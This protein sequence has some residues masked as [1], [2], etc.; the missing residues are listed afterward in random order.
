MNKTLWM[1]WFQGEEDASLHGLNKKCIERWR[2]LNPDWDVR[3]IDNKDIEEII[4][5]YFEIIGKNEVKLATR[6]EVVRIL[7]LRKFGG[8]WSDA[9]VYP[10]VPL[11]EFIPKVLNDTGFF[12]YRFTPRSLCTGKPGWLGDRETVSWFLVADRSEH[13]LIVKWADAYLSRFKDWPDQ[14]KYFQ[15]HEDLASLYDTDE[16]VRHTIDNMVQISEKIPHSAR[17]LGWERREPSFMYK[18][19][20]KIP[21]EF[22]KQK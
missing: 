9:S 18:R 14:P 4:P 1:C 2:E 15:F 11:S 13:P 3:V 19:P 6:G 10:M 16:Q 22:L 21:D 17:Y 5:E 8:V 7:L 12:S 20:K